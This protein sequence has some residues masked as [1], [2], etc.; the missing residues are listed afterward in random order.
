MGSLRKQRD[1][2][3]TID[4]ITVH[5]NRWYYSE[6]RELAQAAIDACRGQE[7][8][9]ERA[10]YRGHFDGVP[11]AHRKSAMESFV[12]YIDTTSR[13]RPQGTNPREYLTEWLDEAI[14]GH[15]FVIYTYKAKLVMVATDNADAY[16][17]EH[18]EA[19][20]KPE[21]TACW[22]MRADVWEELDRREDEWEIEDPDPVDA[23]VEKLRGIAEITVVCEPETIP[24]EGNILV[25]GDAKEDR[26]AAQSARVSLASGNVWA[27][28]CVTVTAVHDGVTGFDV[29]GACSYESESAFRADQYFTDMVTTALTEL[30]RKLI[31][32]GE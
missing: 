20:S 4:A 15:E 2:S 13:E 7:I 11:Y 23:M 6:I 10:K 27:W 17:A 5:L 19:S 28:G 32:R 22:A 8:T 12:P 18:G 16:E 30:A 14:D 24:P 26:I 25:S 9:V 31:A 21:V 29:M 3:S 1:K